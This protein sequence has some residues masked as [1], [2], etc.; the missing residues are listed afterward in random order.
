MN[1]KKALLIVVVSV[2]ALVFIVVAAAGALATAAVG[3]LD[4]GLGVDLED[5]GVRRALPGRREASLLVH[6]IGRHG[7]GSGKFAVGFRGKLS[8][9]SYPPD[10][11][12]AEEPRQVN[13]GGVNG[14]VS[15]VES[16]EHSRL[17]SRVYGEASMAARGARRSGS[18]ARSTASTG[19]EWVW[20]AASMRMERAP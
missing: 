5:L 2:F 12:A 6:Q 11:V 14:E 16:V 7:K 9:H 13:R 20:S 18:D 8:D 19:I 10:V 17:P 4:A 1:W 3:A 15:Y